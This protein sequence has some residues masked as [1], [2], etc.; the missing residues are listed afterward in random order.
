MLTQT[1]FAYAL[2]ALSASPTLATL[3][4]LGALELAGKR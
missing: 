3:L 4:V 1:E 2:R